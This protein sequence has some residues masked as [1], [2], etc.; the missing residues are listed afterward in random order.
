MPTK[1]NGR[2]YEMWI[3]ETPVENRD[4][5]S[6]I[7]AVARDVGAVR[8]TQDKQ[9]KDINALLMTQESQSKD[10]DTLKKGEMLRW[11]IL[12]GVVAIL[13][14]P[15]IGVFVG[16]GRI[17]ERIEHM[18]QQIERIGDDHELRIRGLERAP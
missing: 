10:I 8:Q 7:G 3:E 14:L 5:A 4:L 16:T 12:G 15:A 13:L 17:L 11:K 1:R 18:S 2:D 9:A 6:L